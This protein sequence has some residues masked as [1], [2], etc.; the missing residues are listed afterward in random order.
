MASIIVVISGAWLAICSYVL[1]KIIPSEILNLC[2][3]ATI[4]LNVCEHVK[5]I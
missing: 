1:T 3:V 4:R 5:R 2:S